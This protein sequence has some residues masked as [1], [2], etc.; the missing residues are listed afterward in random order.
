M[1]QN[2]KK[3]LI[4]YTGDVTKNLKSGIWNASRI[5]SNLELVK[6]LENVKLTKFTGD[7]DE[8]LKKNIKVLVPVNEKPQKLDGKQEEYEI[9]VKLFFLDGENIDIKKREETLSQVFYN[10]HMLFGIDFVS[11]LVVSFPHI[12]FLKESGNSSSNEIYDSIDEI[13]PQEIQSWVDT[14]KLLEEKVG[15]GKIGTLGVSEFGVNEL[16][17]LISSVNV[18]PESTQINIGQ[19]CKLPNDL[20]NF[21]D[22]HHLK[23]FFHS[24]PSALLSESEITSVI[25]KACPEIPNPARVDWVIRYT[26]LTRHTAVIHQKG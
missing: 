18:V 5:K 2:E 4:L 11:T 26:I 9:I 14:W 13:P 17:R 25:H 21:A 8:N 3:H 22:R 16:Q 12:T 19:N 15:E 6:A 20:L 7:G 23:L 24:D 1:I 10:L